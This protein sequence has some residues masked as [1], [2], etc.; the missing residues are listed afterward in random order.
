MKWTLHRSGYLTGFIK[1]KN[2][3]QHR[4]VWTQHNGPIPP[5]MQIHHINGNKTDN[6]IEN[7]A[8][9]TKT[10]NEQ[11]MDKARKGYTYNKK[12][13]KYQA[14]RTIDGKRKY[15]GLF[16]TE[17]GAYMASKMA[18]ITHRSTFTTDLNTQDI[19]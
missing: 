8:L 18:H 15:F 4:H 14:Q 10:Q 12:S 5:K 19:G 16:I 6:R 11:K 7:L 1:G 13:N 2:W 3:S 9:V 17:C